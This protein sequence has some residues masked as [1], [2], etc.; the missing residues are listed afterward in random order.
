MNAE[1]IEGMK[2]GSERA[3]EG[4]ARRKTKPLLQREVITLNGQLNGGVTKLCLS[5]NV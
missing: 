5:L 2:E 4:K 1:G 3:G